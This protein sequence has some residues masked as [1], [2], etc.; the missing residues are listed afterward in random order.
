MFSRNQ[1]MIPCSRR[2]K[3]RSQIEYRSHQLLNKFAQNLSAEL[4]AGGYYVGSGILITTSYCLIRYSSVFDAFF[5]LVMVVILIY[6]TAIVMLLL[7]RAI[8]I[9]EQSEEVCKA[10]LDI[11]PLSKADY[12]F[13]KSCHPVKL[14]VGSVG[15][16]ETHE[17]LIILFESVVLQT[18]INL[19]LNF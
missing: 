10:F 15:S 14:K 12:L 19:L 18:T 9:R 4:V 6:S 16:I 3:L 1:A 2:Y 13:W 17:F 11:I 7:T 8:N 5:L